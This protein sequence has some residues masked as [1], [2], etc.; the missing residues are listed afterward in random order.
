MTKKF[1]SFEEL[2]KIHFTNLEPDPEP[3]KIFEETRRIQYLDAHFSNKG[4]GGKTVTVI[5]GFEG[6]TAEIKE[7]TKS[8]KK[9]IGVGG[10]EKNGDIIIQGNY[11]DQI[12]TLLT[13]MGHKVKRVGG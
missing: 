1:S 5:K 12:I 4:R 10:T 11:R 7:L 13:S 2:S 9:A 3:E 8:L 6:T